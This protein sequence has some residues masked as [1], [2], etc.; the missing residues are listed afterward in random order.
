[1]NQPGKNQFTGQIYVLTNGGSFSNSVIVSSA[2]K[3]YSRTI[4][5]GTETGGNPAV[6]AGYARDFELP[7]TKIRVEIPTKR[8]TMT[9]LSAN[10]G[11]GL[12]PEYEIENSIED[13]IGRFDRQIDFVMKLIEKG[14]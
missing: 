8:F 11:N 12:I 14:R 2:L 6:L 10:T 5:V 1:L 4:F 9:S 7:N 13:N 3:K